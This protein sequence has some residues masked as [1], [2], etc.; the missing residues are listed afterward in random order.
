MIVLKSNFYSKYKHLLNR[1][2]DVYFMNTIDILN[3]RKSVRD[4]LKKSVDLDI[5]G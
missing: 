3:T 4:Y 1:K 5:E 2:G